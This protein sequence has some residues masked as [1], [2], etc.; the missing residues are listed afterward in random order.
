MMMVKEDWQD[1]PH[2]PLRDSLWPSVVQG[3]TPLTSARID[4]KSNL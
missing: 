2:L 1:K 3:C 4:I